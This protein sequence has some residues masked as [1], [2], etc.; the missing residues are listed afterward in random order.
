M[1]DLQLIDGWD[2]AVRLLLTIVAGGLIGLN[3]DQHGK[4]GGVRTTILVCL[5]A[6]VAM[7]QANLLLPTAGKAS[8]SFVVLD[9]MRLPLGILTGVGFLGAGAILHRP[10]FIIGLTTAATLWI[11]TVIGLCFGGGQ[12][13]LGAAATAITLGVLW[14]LKRIEGRMRQLRRA[15]LI[16]C[17]RCNGD[18][19][20]RSTDALRQAQVAV[21]AKRLK[22][23]N[24]SRTVEVSYSL[25]WRA[26]REDAEPPAFVAAVAALPDVM[27]LE[28]RP[29]NFD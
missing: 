13:A 3:R 26:L 4:A 29:Q 12:L 2:V 18:A 6:S 9:L 27:T 17:E 21:A 14:G 15:E 20:L 1:Q 19:Q 25:R 10:G 8:N 11:T 7:L 28:W 24:E 5:A 16:L 22:Y 23:F